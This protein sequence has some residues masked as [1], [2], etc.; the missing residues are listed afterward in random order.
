MYGY[1]PQPEPFLKLQLYSPRWKTRVATLLRDG[2]MLGTA[3]EVF[4]S[5]VGYLAQFF[6]DH[7]ASPPFR[8]ATRRLIPLPATQG[9]PVWTGCTCTVRVVGTG[10]FSGRPFHRH[11]GPTMALA[12]GLQ[13]RCPRAPRIMVVPLRCAGRLR[14]P[15]RLNSI[16]WLDITFP[17]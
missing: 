7:G 5:H 9:S 10:R 17:R 13:P 6:M 4:E 2:A 1:H 14:R 16:S 15:P 8:A 12:S 3:F 11:S